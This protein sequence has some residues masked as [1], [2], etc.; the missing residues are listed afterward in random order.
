[1]LCILF[2][3]QKAAYEMRIS[4][5]SSD[6]CSS[7]L[8]GAEVADQALDRPGGRVAQRADRVALDLLGDLEQRIDLARLGV[9]GTQPFHHA[10]HPAGAFA[11]RGAL[12]ATLVLVKMRDATDRA[13][14]V[15]R[16]RSEEPT[17]ELQS[18]MR[19]SY[20]VFCLK[21]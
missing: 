10:P 14:D 13:D 4:D 12:A 2:F 17:S 20:A 8:F 3:K 11:T 16:L 1:M 7:D 9:A 5:W 21:Q 19:L 6:V 15:G 18:I